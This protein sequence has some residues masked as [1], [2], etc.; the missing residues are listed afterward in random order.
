MARK[1]VTAESIL[2]ILQHEK[3]RTLMGRIAQGDDP[4]RAGAEMAGQIL[5]E[6]LAKVMGAAGAPT[7]VDA[8]VVDA[9]YTVINVTEQAKKAS[10]S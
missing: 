4:R 8:N 1:V 10:K 5:A 6:K 9:E 3:T 2:S 7:V